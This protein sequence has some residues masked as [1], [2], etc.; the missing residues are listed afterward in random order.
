MEEIFN[1][2][3]YRNHLASFYRYPCDK[4]DYY[5]R[6]NY[7]QNCYSDEYLLNIIERTKQFIIFLMEKMNK[8]RKIF[9]SNIYDEIEFLYHDS[10]PLSNNCTGGWSC[11]SLFS[12][13]EEKP[14]IS[15]YLLKTYFGENF[16]I[17]FGC[18]SYDGF[19]EEEDCGLEYGFETLE[20]SG[21]VKAFDELYN[22]KYLSRKLI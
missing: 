12:I 8:E 1:L 13:N 5:K 9:D 17:D 14:L 4:D 10:Y 15:I 21:S 19:T 2:D 11:D 6:Y 18:V 3:N 16:I 20:I 22:G 7:I